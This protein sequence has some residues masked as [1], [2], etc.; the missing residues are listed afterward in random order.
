MNL[1]I[2]IITTEKDPE[3]EFFTKKKIGE[4]SDR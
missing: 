2:I 4:A 1:C 3:T